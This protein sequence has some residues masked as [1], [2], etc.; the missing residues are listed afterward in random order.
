MCPQ[1]RPQFNNTLA[2]KSARHPIKEKLQQSKFVPNDVYATQQTRLQII[3]G[4]NMS[5]KSTYIRSIALIIVMAQI[6]SFVPAAYATIPIQRQLFARVSVDDSI[7]SNVSTFAAEM[8][9]MAF[10]LRNIQPHSL[11][12][13]DELGRGTSSRDGLAIAIAIA[14]ALVETRALIWFVTHFAELPAVLA[15]RSGVTSLHLAVH[16]PDAATMQMLYK[17][18]AGA[19]REKH[20]GLALGRLVAL[21]DA[22]LERAEHV[23]GLLERQAMQR[24][25]TSLAVL[26]Q[27]RRRLILNLKEQLTQAHEGR[28]QGEALRAWLKQLREEFVVRMCAVDDAVVAAEARA[29]QQRAE[30]VFEAS[31]VETMSGGGREAPGQ[32]SFEWHDYASSD[33]LR[34]S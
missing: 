31:E 3:T 28:M 19:V 17:V 10:I 2:F 11:A 22:L 30:E 15:E 6:G 12:I 9:E 13:I 25:E 1:V 14:E 34:T 29:L 16:M 18:T 27:R 21:P 7:E 5:G 33:I 8:R 24:R 4:A 23:A 20:Y 26:V 32:Q